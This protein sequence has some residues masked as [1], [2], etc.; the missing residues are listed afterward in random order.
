MRNKIKITLYLFII[1]ILFVIIFVEPYVIGQTTIDINTSKLSINAHIAKQVF[2]DYFSDICKFPKSVDIGINYLKKYRN[3]DL[4]KNLSSYYDSRD[5]RKKEIKFY[6]IWIQPKENDKHFH[7]VIPPY[8]VVYFLG[9]RDN[10]D[11][12]CTFYASDENGKILFLEVVKPPPRLKIRF[13][14]KEMKQYS[15][16]FNITKKEI[17]QCSPS[18]SAVIE[19]VKDWEKII[20]QSIDWEEIK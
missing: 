17:L 6:R 19:Q 4:S 1:L 5:G 10:G 9:K 2:S 16:T 14:P 13:L 7:K 3:E 18:I 12:F 15:L 11:Y 8:S 20:S